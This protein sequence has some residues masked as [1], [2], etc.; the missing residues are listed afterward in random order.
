MLF[1]ET[2][3]VCENHREHTHTLYGQKTKSVPHRKQ[4]TSPP[5]KSMRLLLFR[6]TVDVYCENHTEHT[7][8]LCSWKLSQYLTESTSCLHYKAQLVNAVTV[9]QPRVQTSS[10]WLQAGQSVPAPI[11][12][13]LP[14]DNM[15]RGVTVVQQFRP[16]VR[17]GA[18]QRQHNN[19]QTDNHIWSQVPE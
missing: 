15:V 9:K 13:S 18:S 2:V 5:Q 19:L 10:K 17:E 11:V 16:L 7:N 1:M 14:L 6:K 8:T 12:N 3:A 4:L